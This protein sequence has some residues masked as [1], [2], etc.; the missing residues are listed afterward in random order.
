VW[1][2][3]L[4]VKRFVRLML[5]D[6]WPQVAYIWE[7]RN[8]PRAMYMCFAVFAPEAGLEEADAKAF[9]ER[10]VDQFNVYMEKHNG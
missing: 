5:Q 7:N 10:H 3:D 6:I 4:G 1:P 8:H 9:Y 2:G